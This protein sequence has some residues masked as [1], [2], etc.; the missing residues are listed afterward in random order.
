MS[1]IQNPGGSGGGGDDD[2]T[3]AEVPF[4]PAGNIA[5]TDVQSAIVELDNEK[6]PIGADYLVGTS[7]AGLSAEIVVGTTPGGELGNTWASPTVDASHSGSTH[8]ATQAAAEATAAAALAAHEADSTSIHG[9][10]NTAN[11]VVGPASATDDAI[12][13][14]NGTTG[15]LVKDSATLLSAKQNADATLTALA[16]YNTN[17]LITQTAADTFTGRTITGTANRVGVTNGDGVAGNPTLTLPDTT[18]TPGSYTST[19][20]TVTQDG[21]ITAAANGSGGGTV[22]WE[23]PIGLRLSPATNVY[24]G[25]DSLVTSGTIYWTTVVSGGTGVVTGY[26]GAALARKTVQQKS[27]ALTMTIDKNYDVFY[28][29]DGDVLALSAAWT[30]DT[31]RADALADEQG[32]IVLGSDHTKLWLGTIRAGSANT[33][34][35]SS[36]FRYVANAYNVVRR[37][38]NYAVGSSNHTYNS[39]T[40]RSYNNSTTHRISVLTAASTVADLSPTAVFSSCSATGAT[41]IGVGLDVTNA[42]TIQQLV[43]AAE[44][45]PPYIPCWGTGTLTAGYHFLQLIE[46]VDAGTSTFDWGSIT[47]TVFI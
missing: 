44:T 36:Q 12:V 3:A 4:T 7:N 11:L 8:A 19:D 46:S 39:A 17:G 10:T 26:N 5:A 21:R 27:L 18:V 42:P 43:A 1:H 38:L 31:T 41:R 35:D 14:F 16:A 28:D 40:W 37:N 25:G 9:I 22:T 15:K 45:L 2:Q 20:L 6:A 30:N 29:Y 13:L 34:W 32:A 47:G 23:P 33:V 24:V